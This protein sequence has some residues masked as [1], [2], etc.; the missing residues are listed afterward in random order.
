M[1][2]IVAGGAKAQMQQLEMSVSLPSII[3]GRN[4]LINFP[5]GLTPVCVP[6]Q[7]EWGPVTLQVGLREEMDE[8][9]TPSCGHELNAV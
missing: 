8:A 9:G 6:F 1:A 5:S 3:I 2:N 7:C 4:Y